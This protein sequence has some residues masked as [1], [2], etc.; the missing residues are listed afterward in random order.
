MDSDTAEL[1]E[2]KLTLLSRRVRDLKEHWDGSEYGN[3]YE[4]LCDI[5]NTA[6]KTKKYLV[7]AALA[8]MSAE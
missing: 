8:H 5:Q 4:T 1:V 2:K 7:G 6:T 3:M